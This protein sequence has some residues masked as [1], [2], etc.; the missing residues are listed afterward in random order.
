MY[1]HIDYLEKI[2]VAAN[3]YTKYNLNSYMC[4][5]VIVFNCTMHIHK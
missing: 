1:F 5:I 4:V 2:L 3:A